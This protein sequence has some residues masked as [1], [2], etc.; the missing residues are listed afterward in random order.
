MPL[1]SSPV[2]GERCAEWAMDVDARIEYALE[3]GKK[4]GFLRTDDAVI[5]VTGWRK[6]AGATNTLR[7]VYVV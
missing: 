2:A 5:V 7:V 3:I 4:R 1:S 6:G